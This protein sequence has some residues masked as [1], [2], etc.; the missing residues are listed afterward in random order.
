M[1]DEQSTYP[2]TLTPPHMN[3]TIPIS[4]P[5][6]THTYMHTHTRTPTYTHTHTLTHTH[7]HTHTHRNDKNERTCS[8]PYELETSATHTLDVRSSPSCS[9]RSPSQP[10][11]A[12]VGRDHWSLGG[13]REQGREGA[14]ARRE[15]DIVEVG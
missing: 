13:S 11:R 1:D 6:H 9:P 2:P 15:D 10:G 14:V 8:C 4:N 5:T 12:V 3:T 7:T